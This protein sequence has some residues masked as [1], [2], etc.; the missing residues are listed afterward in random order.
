[1]DHH[2]GMTL[3][4]IAITGHRRL[5]DT[6]A[7]TAAV[8]SILERLARSGPLVLL[9]PLAE[10][11]DRLAA[12]E[13]LRLPGGVLRAILPL[14]VEDYETDFA[15]PE[16]RTEFRE[17]VDRAASVEVLPPQPTRTDAYLAVGCH[18][19]DGCD[20]VLAVWDGEPAR[21]K[22]GTAEVV[23]YARSL[24]K[25]LIIIDSTNPGEIRREGF[26]A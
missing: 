12:R 19:V 18:I 2:P 24:G 6:M 23:A 4:N 5:D 1:M 13:I 26:D 10:G 8:G 15:T 25:P 22:G 3:S 16:S 20:I 9:S 14:P 7:V 11:A 17:L 21:G